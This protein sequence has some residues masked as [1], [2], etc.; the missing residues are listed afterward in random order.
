[1]RA[2][3]IGYTPSLVVYGSLNPLLGETYLL[4]SGDDI[5]SPSFSCILAVDFLRSVLCVCY[6][7]LGY[8]IRLSLFLFVES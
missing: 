3:L 4:Q 8:I 6:I 1:M 5:S 2:T 7:A